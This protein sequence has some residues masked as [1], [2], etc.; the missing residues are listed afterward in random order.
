[1]IKTWLPLLLA[2]GVASVLA[3]SF[4]LHAS[5]GLLAAFAWW[6]HSRQAEALRRHQESTA[7]ELQRLRARAGG[8]RFAAPG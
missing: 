8:G 6:L 7:A 3:E 5:I 1:M 2:F 4:G